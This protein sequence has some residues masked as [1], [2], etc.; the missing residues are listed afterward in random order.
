MNVK[1]SDLNHL[2]KGTLMEQL[3]IE[4]LEAEPGY[5]KARMPVNDRTRQPMGILHGGASVALAET[6]AG[7]GS[8][9]LVDMKTYDVKGAQLSANHVGS[10]KEGYVF[11]H[12]RILHQGKNTHLWDVEIKDENDRMIS[13]CRLTNFITAK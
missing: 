4:Y 13:I 8:T 12:A 11:A 10:I 1:L 2:N 5:V 9:L 6:V 3:Q 7:L